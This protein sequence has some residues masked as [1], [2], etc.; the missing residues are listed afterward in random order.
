VAAR[1]EVNARRSRRYAEGARDILSMLELAHAED[2]RPRSGAKLRDELV[3]LLSDRPTATSLPWALDRLT[4]DPKRMARLRR[5]ALADEG[6]ANADAVVKET[7]R[8]CPAVPVAM[9]A[10]T[11]P[12]RLTGRTIPAGTSVADCTYL[13]DLRANTYPEPLEFRPERFLE[14]PAG[15]YSW[16]PR[17]ERSEAVNSRPAFRCWRRGVFCT[18]W[19]AGRSSRRWMTARQA[20]ARS[21]V[22]FAPEGGAR[23]L[24]RRSDGLVADAA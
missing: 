20:A 9:C 3:T 10:F 21:S 6:D 1:E 24:A 17:R 7:L 15:T 2:G 12:L 19:R 14:Q 22:S 5:E 13:L 11:T 23:V 8:L 18:R 4:R 16:D